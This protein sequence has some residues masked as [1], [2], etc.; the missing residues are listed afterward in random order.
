[1]TGFFFWSNLKKCYILEK[2]SLR[3]KPM[4]PSIR[5]FK[6]KLSPKS[7]EI[8]GGQIDFKILSKDY[9]KIKDSLWTALCQQSCRTN[10]KIFNFEMDKEELRSL[11]D[12]RKEE[13]DSKSFVEAPKDLKAISI[14]APF[15]YAICKGLKSEE[16]RSQNTKLRGWVLIHAS[17][18]KASDEWLKIYGLTKNITRGAIIGAAYIQEV[19]GKPGEYA[20]QISDY[21]LFDS[22]FK[23]IKGRQSIFWGAKTIEEKKAF[24]E[25]WKLI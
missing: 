21:R 1:M 3:E 2:Y 16:Y 25:A 6:V 20:Y 9:S 24:A 12:L 13:E 15:A 10:T 23:G 4:K 8:K 14:H 5:V 7:L 11:Y 18:S 19:V 22:P 17:Q